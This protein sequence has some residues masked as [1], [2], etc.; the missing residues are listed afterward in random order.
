MTDIRTLVSDSK[1][2]RWTALVVVAFTMFAGYFI[3]D[4]KVT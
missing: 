3:A 4:V 1:A 2:A